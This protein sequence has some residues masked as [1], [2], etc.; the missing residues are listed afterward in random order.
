MKQI[1][2]TL[3]G[4]TLMLLAGVMLISS[5]ALASN[6]NRGN[7][8]TPVNCTGTPTDRALIQSA[9]N[10][11]ASGDVLMLVNTCQLDGTQVF[12]TKSNLTITGAGKAGNWSTVV[13]GIASGGGTPVGDGA[14]FFNRG[15]QI[16][17][18]SGNSVV[19]NVEI[20]NIKFS[21]LHRGVI[22]SAQIGG[23]TSQCSG[24]TA[25]T[26]SASSI[27]VENNWFDNDDRAAQSFGTANNV[28]FQNNLVTNATGGAVDFIIEGQVVAC[29][30]G[31]GF[32]SIG[33]PTNSA[34][35]G[36]SVS[37][38]NESQPIIVVGADKIAVTDNSLAALSGL[39]FGMIQ[40]SELSNSQVSNNQIDGGGTAPGVAASDF[41]SANPGF[42]PNS[43]ND[44]I[45]NN[46]ISNAVPGV[47]V[48]SDTTGYSV[49]N[50][51]FVNS[52]TADIVL[53]GTVLNAF[54]DGGPTP[55]FQNKVVTTNFGNSVIDNGTN[56]QLLG[57]Q[58]LINNASVPAGV[59]ANLIGSAVGRPQS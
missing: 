11:A 43:S 58:N 38:G 36:N 50:N 24:T 56:N 44:R 27:V 42:P 39:P 55:S 8:I 23:N 6:P 35:T 13:Q 16:G 47:G 7:N 21:T 10:N 22:A 20:S 26:G 31:A 4:S 52:S 17:N 40:L 14:T 48:D 45:T 34:V 28:N 51:Q 33:V 30:G 18:T 19:K 46:I 25:G 49:V 2:K 12:I 41:Q 53:C 5:L 3:L 59:I 15:F 57:T 1:H 9:V 29:N 37:G 54:C 32:V